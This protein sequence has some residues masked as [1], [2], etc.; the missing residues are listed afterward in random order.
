VSDVHCHSW[1]QFSKTNSEGINSRLATILAELARAAE[2]V[3]SVGGT[4]LRVAGDLFHVR[5]KIEPSVFN[6]TYDTFREITK[7]GIRVEIIPGNHDLEGHSADRLGNAMQQ[8]EQIEGVTVIIEPTDFGDAVMVPWIED[9]DEL[10][11]TCKSFAHRDKDLIIHA[12]LN[13]VIK[14]LPDLGLDPDEIA[15]WG[16][17]R[18]FVGH[19]HAHREFH[20]GKVVSIGATTHQTWSDP[21]TVAGFIIAYEDRIEHHETMAPQFVNIDDPAEID[22]L[23]VNGNYVRLRLKDADEKTLAQAKVDLESNGALDWVDHSSKK[24]DTIRAI[25]TGPQNLSLEVSV[26]G[27][28]MKHLPD[29]GLEK[30]RIAQDALEVL[31]EARTVGD[32]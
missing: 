11:T 21:G 12:P 10:R 30:R 24:R 31:R 16:F 15:Q 9:L 3:R 7:L 1:S 20:A 6:P 14:G 8:L 22:P 23:T 5:G 27:F 13:G 29:N 4:T 26:A 32:E 17:H 25:S 2:A 19:Y 18:V 28:V